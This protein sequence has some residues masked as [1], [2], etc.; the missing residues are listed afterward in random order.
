MIKILLWVHLL[1]FLFLV[2]AGSPPVYADSMS[3]DYIKVEVTSISYIGNNNYRV[4]IA[5]LNESAKDYLIIKFEKYYYAQTEILGQ[6]QLLKSTSVNDFTKDDNPYVSAK[7]KKIIAT[8][9][10]IP[11]TIPNL[12]LNAYGDINIKFIYSLEFSENNRTDTY[13]N[14]VESSYWITP[15]TNKWV[16]REGM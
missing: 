10:N 14:S 7:E 11:L 13:N 1:I 15:E 4:K 9:V 3:A 5:L 2:I 16:L 8:T 6:W 12:Y